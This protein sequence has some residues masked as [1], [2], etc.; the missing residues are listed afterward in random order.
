M[1]HNKQWSLTIL[2]VLAMLTW[3]L[4]WTNAKILGFYAN[5]PLIMF[6]RFFLASI[7]FSFVLKL[8][9]SSFRIPPHAIPI[10][11]FNSVSMV[12]YNYFYFKGTQIGLAGT[13]GVLVTTLNPILTTI[14]SSILLKEL[15]KKKDWLGLALGLTGGVIILRIWEM[16][17]ANFYHSGNLFFILASLSWVSVTIITSKSKLILSFFPYSFWSFVFATFLSLPLSL[18]ADLFSIF[19]FDW[20]FWLNLIM[21]SAFAM[22]FGTSIYFLASTKLGPKKASSYIFLVPLTAI[23]FAMYFLDEPLQ[24]STLIGGA[25][26]MFA[27]YLININ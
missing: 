24:L 5:A 9:N 13:G 8:S 15:M 2:M 12:S 25:L 17:F 14:I 27:V 18:N 19:Y 3:G 21:L 26:G 10:T 1:L 20:V 6:W 7:T 4:S 22:A 11:I 23:L 16:S